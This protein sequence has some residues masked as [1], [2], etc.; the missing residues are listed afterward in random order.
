MFY[1]FLNA[2]PKERPRA[3]NGSMAV[4]LIQLA[5]NRG[6]FVLGLA[7]MANF[8]IIGKLS[9]R[10]MYRFRP[11]FGADKN[12]AFF[13]AS[14]FILP[15]YSEGLPVAALEAMSFSLPCLLSTACNI[16]EAFSCNAAI[17]AEP[18]ISELIP[19]LNTLFNNYD[20]D[21]IDMGRNSRRLV[22]DKFNGIPSLQQLLKF[23]VD[24]GNSTRLIVCF[25][26]EYYIE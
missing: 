16:P 5:R 4:S 13:H 22:E 14:S 11:L 3:V 24:A 23:T 20:S 2:S 19:A 21:F 7:M 17:R 15:S 26:D 10:K 25:C 18:E 1:Y 8:R 6:C 9:N 12:S